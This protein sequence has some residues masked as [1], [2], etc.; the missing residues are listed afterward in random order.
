MHSWT[1]GC[2][3][4]RPLRSTLVSLSRMSQ[5]RLLALLVCASLAL[6]L[7]GCGNKN[8]EPPPREALAT[9][10]ERARNLEAQKADEARRRETAE[11][12]ASAWKTA[13]MVSLSGIVVALIVGVGIGS[14]A[15]SK[16]E[17]SHHD[18]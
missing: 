6:G 5:L 16:A 14:R 10:K 1:A 3:T 15:R 2:D 13:T 12:D 11:K 4:G 18:K 8:S 9:E 17:R 7:A